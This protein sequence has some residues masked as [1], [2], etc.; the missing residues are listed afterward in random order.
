MKRTRYLKV[1]RA[2]TLLLAVV[3]AGLV[4]WYH[5]VFCAGSTSALAQAQGS[6]VQPKEQ[7][8]VKTRLDEGD[9]IKIGLLGDSLAANGDW[10]QKLANR[11]SGIYDCTVH[12]ENKSVPVTDAY[13]GYCIAEK[14]RDDWS[15]CDV[16]ILC[17]G[18]RE[19]ILGAPAEEFTAQ[20][21]ASVLTLQEANPQMEF[22]LMVSNYLTDSA[23]IDAI[24]QLAQAYAIP[25]V[26]MNDWF[27]E[28][29]AET[30][31]TEPD[32]HSLPNAEGYAQ[33]AVAASN[34]IRQGTAVLTVPKQPV[35]DLTAAYTGKWK[36]IK[37]KQLQTLANRD[38]VYSGKNNG[39]AK[40]LGVSYIA[41]ESGEEQ[42]L[43]LVNGELVKTIDAVCSQQSDAE[44]FVLCAADIGKKDTVEIR[45]TGTGARLT[46]VCVT[47]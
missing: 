31:V 29:R 42:I 4:G 38:Y 30:L 1:I 23:Y 32:V 34:Q 17:F 47:E 44:R 19:Q 43:V 46:G 11:L 8:S 27:A 10:A 12:V 24:T 41:A 9:S 16:A 39:K 15:S 3:L 28:K 33:Y 6:A 45:L 7:S 22:L 26:N 37:A 40:R 35:S 21:E 36:Q 13:Q 20:L 5:V 2:G 25:C 14:D 18:A